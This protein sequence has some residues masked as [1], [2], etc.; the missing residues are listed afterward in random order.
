M[1][2]MQ[3][4]INI[5]QEIPEEIATKLTMQDIVEVFSIMLNSSEED[6]FEPKIEDFIDA[7]YINLS[8]KR[9]LSDIENGRTC[10]SEELKKEL[11]L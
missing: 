9:G 7:L 8:I 6:V 5:L 2:D 3:K 11:G 1:S 4:T 10:T